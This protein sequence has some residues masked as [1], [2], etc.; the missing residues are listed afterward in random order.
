M[1]Q[2]DWV[3]HRYKF[4]LGRYHSATPGTDKVVELNRAARY[5][6]QAQVMQR[7]GQVTDFEDELVEPLT[8]S[9]LEGTI[10]VS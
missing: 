5:Y 8:L 3:I 6:Y 2:L 4:H 7:H 1:N 10:Y 9:E